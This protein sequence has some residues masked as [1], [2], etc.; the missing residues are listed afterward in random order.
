[1]TANV[2]ENISEQ[3]INL[4]LFK[5][6]SLLKLSVTVQPKKKEEVKNP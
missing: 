6:Y 4:F 1:M 5:C 3:I 2:I